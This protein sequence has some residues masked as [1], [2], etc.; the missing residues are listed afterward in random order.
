MDFTLDEISKVE[1]DDTNKK[2]TNPI[3]RRYL[4]DCRDI[5]TISL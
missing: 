2:P 1:I 4:S 3:A 5:V